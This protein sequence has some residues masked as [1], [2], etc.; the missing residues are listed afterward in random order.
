V[1]LNPIINGWCSW[2]YTHAQATEDEQLPN[3]EF[4]ARRHP[5]W[6]IHDAHGRVQ[7]DPSAAAKYALDVTHP[8]ARRWLYELFRAIR[9]DWGYEFI[10]TD[11]PGWTILA[12]ERYHDPSFHL[13]AQVRLNVVAGHTPV[14]GQLH[15]TVGPA[16]GFGAARIFFVSSA[17]RKGVAVAV[18][19]HFLQRVVLVLD[20]SIAL[21]R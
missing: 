21:T 8:E 14:L 3:A 20:E 11:F 10:K 7:A 6:L 18:A 4:I 2:F 9:H 5:D 17:K 16:A 1:K 12:A 15:R 13:H 19:Q